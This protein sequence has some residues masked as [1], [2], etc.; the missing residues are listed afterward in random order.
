[1]KNLKSILLIIISV[2]ILKCEISFSQ[3]S[4]DWVRN[5]SS[6]Q[7]NNQIPY[8]AVTDTSGNIYITGS[9]C[10]GY[11]TIDMVTIK[12]NSSGE[13]VWGKTINASVTDYSNESGR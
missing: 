11:S 7:L 9:T 10:R 1:M 8:D 6:T 3:V 12:Y 2:I 5:Y 4:Q 13:Y